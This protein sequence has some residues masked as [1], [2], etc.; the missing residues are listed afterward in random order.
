M[1]YDFRKESDRK[2]FYNSSAWRG[3]N[4]V[5]NKVLKRD[6]NECIWC[7]EKGL[8][9]ISNLHIDHILDLE[10]CTYEQALDMD[11]LRTLCRDCHDKRH[12]R[13][14]ETFK[15]NRFHEDERW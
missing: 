12:D 14:Q 9:N 13:F 11:N 1:N 10:H 6:N 3:V 15:R 5:R 2:R 8:V 4:G 7:K